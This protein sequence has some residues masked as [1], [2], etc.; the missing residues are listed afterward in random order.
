MK[1]WVLL[2]SKGREGFSLWGP[3][4][5]CL[6]KMQTLKGKM[7]KHFGS[8][9]Q[10]YVSSSRAVPSMAPSPSIQKEQLVCGCCQ[11]PAVAVNLDVVRGWVCVSPD[12]ST[13]RG[14]WPAWPGEA[15]WLLADSGGREKDPLFPASSAVPAKGWKFPSCFTLPWIKGLGPPEASLRNSVY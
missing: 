9:L 2:F 13:C 4:C 14:A 6:C 10:S 11:V 1:A 7:R 12:A 8:A 15:W 3:W 5:P